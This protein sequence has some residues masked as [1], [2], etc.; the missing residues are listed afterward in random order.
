MDL[1]LNPQ[2]LIEP[3]KDIPEGCVS[4]KEFKT[5]LGKAARDYSDE[6]IE[7]I[8]VLFDRLAEVAFDSWL[9]KVNSGII[10]E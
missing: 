6:E 2:S 5:A 3:Q 10:T 8:R 1:L 4:F 9:K 7:K